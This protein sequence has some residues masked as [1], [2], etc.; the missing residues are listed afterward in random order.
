VAEE[1]R[2]FGSPG[3]TRPFEASGAR[4]FRRLLLDVLFPGR[5]LLC[6]SWLEPGAG[7]PLCATCRESITVDRGP[8]CRRCGIALVS[9]RAVCMRC[10]AVERAFTT[11]FALFPNRGAP[12][13]ILQALKFEGRTRLAPIVAEW[14]A[15]EL[16]R[17]H[18]DVV[19][20]PAPPR[21]ARRG[22]D[23]VERI[24]RVLE[25]RHGIVV[26]R[27]L[28]RT[29][30]VEQKSLDYEERSRNLRGRISAAAGRAVPDRLVLFDDVFTTGATLDAC[31][32]AL[33][34]AGAREVSAITL[35]IEE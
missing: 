14:V 9:E 17:L 22:P 23:A 1:M 4:A 7:T 15:A 28:E 30:G 12:R 21:R 10:R 3:R 31:A 24:C 11:C 34:D 29:G 25:R 16:H 2:P 26:H 35:L 13:E 32:R 18:P 27:L 20:V 33:R 19:V 5:C 6:G 8:R